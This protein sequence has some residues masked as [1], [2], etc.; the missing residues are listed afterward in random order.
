MATSRRRLSPVTKA[1]LQPELVEYARTVIGAEAAAVLQVAG[2]L[3]G[4]F[5]RAAELVLA[6][7]GRV[8][9]TGMG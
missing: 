3:N 1:A 6:C 5:A 7:P 8:V 2:R 9:V 4:E